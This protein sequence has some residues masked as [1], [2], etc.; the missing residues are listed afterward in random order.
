MLG[1]ESQFKEAQGESSE[2]IPL[3][4]DGLNTLSIILNIAHLNFTKVPSHLEFDD[5]LTVAIVTNKYLA[6]HIVR[7][8]VTN[9][10]KH[11]EGTV[12]VQGYEEWLWISWEFGYNN[13]FELV[14]NKLV[15]ESRINSCGECLN[16]E[17]KILKD[18]MPS[19]IIGEAAL[20]VHVDMVGS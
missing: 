18:K 3:P 16:A 6:M 11:L 13:I 19:G 9:W 4:E 14:A 8:W 17:G 15:L 2:E 10:I 5:L 12:G 1:P 7:S 20:Y